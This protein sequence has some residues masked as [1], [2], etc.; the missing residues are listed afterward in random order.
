MKVSY[1]CCNSGV[2]A[3]QTISATFKLRRNSIFLSRCCTYSPK[4]MLCCVGDPVR[5]AGPRPAGEL[6]PARRDRHHHR[7]QLPRGGVRLELRPRHGLRQHHGGYPRW[8]DADRV[9]CL[10]LPNVGVEVW[11]GAPSTPLTSVA[12][13]RCVAAVLERAGLPGAVSTLCQVVILHFFKYLSI[14]IINNLLITIFSYF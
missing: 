6:E 5:E 3:L 4:E 9:S 1:I 11:K 13:T 12:V 14:I 2:K 8:S 10:L 7:L